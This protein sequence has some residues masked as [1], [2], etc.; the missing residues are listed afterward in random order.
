MLSRGGGLLSVSED[1]QRVSGRED[2]QGSGVSLEPIT[3]TFGQV[4]LSILVAVATSLATNYAVNWIFGP[5]LR[6]FFRQGEYGIVKTENQTSPTIISKTLLG[7]AVVSPGTREGAAFI[8]VCVQN[9]GRGVAKGCRG[10]LTDVE[11]D[12]GDG[13]WRR[14]F[15]DA[16]PLN[17][18]YLAWDAP[19]VI[20]L[21][22]EVDANL[23][24][25]TCRQDAE[26][27]APCLATIPLRYEKLLNADSH[28]RLTVIVAAENAKPKKF[29]L[30]VDTPGS[31]Y[32]W[33]RI[34]A[35]AESTALN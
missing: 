28:F 33:E 11:I 30:L 32:L 15:W 20:D 2:N 17:W 29:A 1:R 7:E 10:F 21:P 14:I 31:R 5:Q 12:A 24:V 22:G 3:M 16:I 18:S 23:D 26:L 8:R 4:L 27:A 25:V 19:Q 9:T 6:V 34:T 35:R 13:K